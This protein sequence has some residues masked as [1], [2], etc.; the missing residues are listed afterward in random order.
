MNFYYIIID[1]T[2]LN[3]INQ[4]SITMKLY[5]DLQELSAAVLNGEVCTMKKAIEAK[6]LD[7]SNYQSSE[8]RECPVTTCPLYAF[9]FGKN[10]YKK[11]REYTDEQLAEMRDRMKAIRTKKQ[12]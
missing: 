5:K 6:C 11:K 12:K 2:F 9:R 8:V 3:N 1:N 4:N 10:P 7:C